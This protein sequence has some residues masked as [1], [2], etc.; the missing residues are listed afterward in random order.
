MQ[1][2]RHLKQWFNIIEMKHLDGK[3]TG[4]RYSIL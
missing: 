2:Y 1:D 3:V 4:M